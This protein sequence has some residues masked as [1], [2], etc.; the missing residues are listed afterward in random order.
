MLAYYWKNYFSIHRWYRTKLFEPNDILF[1]V[2]LSIQKLS[3][4]QK[5]NFLL[6]QTDFMIGFDIWVKSVNSTMA[7]TIFVL[8][9]LSWDMSHS[10]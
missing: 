4:K 8:H 5:G 10:T 1:E 6:V 9:Y 7:F 3:H 2:V